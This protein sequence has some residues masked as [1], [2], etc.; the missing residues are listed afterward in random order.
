MSEKFVGEH[1]GRSHGV[2]VLRDSGLLSL[3]FK[4]ENAA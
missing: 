1:F 4:Q 3:L 2:K